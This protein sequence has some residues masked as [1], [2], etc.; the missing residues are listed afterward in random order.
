MPKGL[1]DNMSFGDF[2]VAGVVCLVAIM[3]TT[4]IA[5][6]FEITGILQGVVVYKFRLALHGVTMIAMLISSLFQD[7]SGGILDME[8]IRCLFCI[9]GVL[10]GYFLFYK[11]PSPVV[12]HY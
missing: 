11:R 1:G 3:T 10:A 2:W 4:F 5:F 9:M 8:A 7:W 12:T 6:L